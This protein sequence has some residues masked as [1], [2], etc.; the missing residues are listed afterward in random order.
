MQ[1][2]STIIT[3]DYVPYAL[4]LFHSYRRFLGVQMQVLIIDD[5]DKVKS[6]N[7]LPAE[8]LITHLSDLDLDETGSAIVRKYKNNPEVLRW[9]L[10]P[11]WLRWLLVSTN[12][13]QVFYVDADIYFFSD[14]RFLFVELSESSILL[15]PH[16]RSI[17]PKAD[18]VN[19]ELN[20]R[21]GIYNGGCIGVTRTG[22]PALDWLAD[23]CRY[24]CKMDYARGLFYDQKYLDLLPARFSG[25]K[26][27]THK[28]CNVANWN[29]VDCRRFEWTDDILINGQDPIVFVHFTHSTIHGILNGSD[30]LLTN[31][32]K[33]YEQA[34]R[35]FAPV[36]MDQFPDVSTARQTR[37]FLSKVLAKLSGNKKHG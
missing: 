18:P 24:E 7:T 23:V 21:D 14:P 13:E 10:K 2:F 8:L 36:P 16:W 28:G 37:G 17:D 33:E 29:I 15:C 6:W 27:I 5:A 32:L 4:A 12:L 30:G 9:A 3:S 22:I 31:H 25:V 11:I 19:F 20:F 1:A 26:C 34:L 35:T